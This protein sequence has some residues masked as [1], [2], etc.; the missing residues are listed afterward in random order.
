MILISSRLSA[1]RPSYPFWRKFGDHVKDRSTKKLKSLIGV[2]YAVHVKVHLLSFNMILISSAWRVPI[3]SY[4]FL[5]NFG[6][7]GKGSFTEKAKN[8]NIV[9]RVSLCS[10]AEMTGSKQA[11]HFRSV[12]VDRVIHFGENLAHQVKGRSPKML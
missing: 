4:P 6:R 11:S 10:A 8:V 2:N 3:P 9:K 5:G 1:P 12:F 7:S